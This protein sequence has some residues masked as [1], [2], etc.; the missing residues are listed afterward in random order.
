MF[1]KIQP[2]Q[3]LFWG[4]RNPLPTFILYFCT[5]I[6]E[7]WVIFSEQI[8]QFNTIFWVSS[9]LVRVMVAYFVISWNE[10]FKK[11]DLLENKDGGFFGYFRYPKL[12]KIRN[13][14]QNKGTQNKQPSTLVT[15][16]YFR[17]CHSSLRFFVNNS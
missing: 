8:S 3:T 10:S 15:K 7:I 2:C 11:F 14:L 6:N 16:L 5:F 12:F 9:S 17:L 4:T 1:E 13:P